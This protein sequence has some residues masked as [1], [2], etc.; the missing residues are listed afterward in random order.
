MGVHSM[1]DHNMGR[2]G[3]DMGVNNNGTMLGIDDIDHNVGDHDV[4]VKHDGID[5]GID[6]ID[7]SKGTLSIDG[8]DHGTARS[9]VIDDA[10]AARPPVAVVQRK[11]AWTA[12]YRGDIF[13]DEIVERA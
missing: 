9:T 12:I 11:R 2:V 4:G 1:G 7:H 13:E 3:V 5:G 8:V 6:D 10:W